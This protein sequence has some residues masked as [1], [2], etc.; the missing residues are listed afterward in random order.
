[1]NTKISVLMPVKNAAKYL[2][3]CIQSIISQEEENWELIAVNDHSNDTS[4]EILMD[5]QRRDDRIK[6]FDNKGFGIIPALQTAYHKSSGQLIHR[7]DADDLMPKNKLSLLKENLIQIG[8]GNLVTAKVKYFASEGVSDG[9]QQYEA[10]LNDLCDRG[11]HWESIYKECVVPSP[12]WMVYREDFENCGAFQSDIYPEDYDLCFRFF[13]HGLRVHAIQEVLHLWRDHTERTSRNHEHYQQ[14]A[15]FEIK[16]HYFLQLHHEANRPLVIWG[17]GK[18]GKI[19]AKLLQEKGVKFH[20]V[21][22]N[23]NRE[24]KEVYGQLMQSYKEIIQK[25]NPQVIITVAQRGANKEIEF[26]LDSLQLRKG[27]DYFFFR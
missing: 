18:K 11:L 16:L 7:M 9:Y 5:F 22:N 15:F 20:W 24:G 27:R 19:M 4:K 17:A 6:C 1:M 23:P 2:E 26:F 12:C 3:E 10:W 14:N 8:Q 21:S 13:K 25:D